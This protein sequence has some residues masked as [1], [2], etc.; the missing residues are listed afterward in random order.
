MRKITL[1]EY[2]AIP[3]DYRGIWTV[4]RWDLPD[5]AEIREKHIGKRTMMVYD[6]GT[7]LLVEGMGFEIVDDSSWKKP[8]EVRQKIEDLYL[9]FYSGRGREPHYA[10]C[11]I[12]W[13]DT[14]ESVEV[15]IALSVD[16]DPE[17]DDEIFYYCNGLND[18]KSLAD[19]SMEDFTI[20]ECLGFGIYEEQLQTT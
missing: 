10:E 5:W 18:L 6:N 19:K 2:N 17:K 11:A 20:A 13:N 14:L 4:E 12:R 15:R 7:C 1:S 8:D 16:Y 3:E 9:K